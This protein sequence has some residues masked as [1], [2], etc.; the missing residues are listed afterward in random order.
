MKYK[1]VPD[2]EAPKSIKF[3]GR[4]RFRQNSG[5]VDVTDPEVLEKI[6]NHPAFVLKP[7]KKT[8][9]RKK[10][11]KRAAAPKAAAPRVRVP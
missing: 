6:E 3:M 1:W 10:P 2:D 5:Y 4:V 11:T 9:V 7:E 8:P